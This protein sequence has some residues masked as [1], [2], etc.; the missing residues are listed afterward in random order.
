M[1]D[2]ERPTE[3]AEHLLSLAWSQAREVTDFEHVG[4]VLGNI[5]LGL[6]NISVG[7]RATY[8]EVE[9]L[10]YT[11]NTLRQRIEKLETAARFQS[12]GP[13]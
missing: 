4:R 13:K 9:Q 1:R 6:I 3:L 5:C 12:V 7:L 8:I 2:P 11:I 10:E